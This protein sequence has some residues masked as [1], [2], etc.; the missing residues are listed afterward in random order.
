MRALVLLGSLGAAR[1]YTGYAIGPDAL[2]YQAAVSYC[3]GIGGEIASIHSD[4]DNEA[5]RDACGDNVCWI[6]LR[7]SGG[8]QGTHAFEQIWRWRD[9]STAGVDSYHNWAPGEPEYNEYSDER[10][11]VMNDPGYYGSGSS[12]LWFT[13]TDTWYT[14]VPLCGVNAPTTAPTLSPAPT[15]SPKPT[16]SFSCDNDRCGVSERKECCH[17]SWESPVCSGGYV[18]VR[19]G[20]HSCL[21]TCCTIPVTHEEVTASGHQWEDHEDRKKKSGGGGGGFGGGWA[22]YIFLY[23]LI[24]CGVPATVT[25]IIACICVRCGCCKM[26]L[27]PKLVY[28]DLTATPPT[29]PSGVELTAPATTV[30]APPPAQ[31]YKA[32]IVASEGV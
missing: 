30:N 21:F 16:Y 10:Y 15:S 11:A 5:A 26:C 31:V 7:E 12:G 1:A 18:P 17:S 4:A 20:D 29:I 8:E 23:L 9:N 28:K 32:S 19:F 27:P 25:G 14:V 13:T 22:F 2:S 6:G 3:D 24:W